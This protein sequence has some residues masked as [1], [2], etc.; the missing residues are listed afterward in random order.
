MVIG[1][2]TECEKCKS[3]VRY[4]LFKEQ[5]DIKDQ[6]FATDA[7]QRFK[8]FKQYDQNLFETH[9]LRQIMLEQV[10]NEREDDQINELAPFLFD[11]KTGRLYGNSLLN[12]FEE[13]VSI[14][15]FMIA[16]L[17]SYKKPLPQQ[18]MNHWLLA[19][20]R[21]LDRDSLLYGVLMGFFKL[22]AEFG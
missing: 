15:P 6:F 14:F 20:R 22:K 1:T 4:Y 7:K 11:M 19:I 8:L 3:F 10:F 9:W 16:L 18:V 5:T 21:G 12:P 2:R 17:T 13:V